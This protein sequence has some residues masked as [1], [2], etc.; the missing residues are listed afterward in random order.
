MESDRFAAWFVFRDSPPDVQ[1]LACVG[2]PHVVDCEHEESMGSRLPR[3][4]GKFE[5]LVTDS[6]STSPAQDDLSELQF[7]FLTFSN[8]ARMRLSIFCHCSWV[9]S[10][11]EYVHLEQTAGRAV[12]SIMFWGSTNRV[13]TLYWMLEDRKEWRRTAKVINF[14]SFWSKVNSEICIVFYVQLSI[15]W[16]TTPYTPQPFKTTNCHR[17]FTTV[18]FF[19]MTSID[20]SEG[21]RGEPRFNAQHA[22]EQANPSCACCDGKHMAMA[23]CCACFVHDAKPDRRSVSLSHERQ[24]EGQAVYWLIAPP[25]THF[26]GVLYASSYVSTGPQVCGRRI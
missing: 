10:F 1:N 14:I 3:G 23:P 22:R 20:T 8:W 7:E 17:V 18:S 19:C 15:I 6:I 24:N 11:I 25:M 2:F 4:L 12:G 9:L 13:W 16:H 26:R 5:L 21:D